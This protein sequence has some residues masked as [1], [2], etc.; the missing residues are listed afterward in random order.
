MRVTYSNQQSATVDRSNTVIFLPRDLTV[1][2]PRASCRAVSPFRALPTNESSYLFVQQS[3]QQSAARALVTTPSLIRP[4]V[5]TIGRTAA[6][7]RTRFLFPS[8]AR[9]FSTSLATMTKVAVCQILSTNDPAHNLAVSSKVI[10]DAVAAGAKVS[11][12]QW[13]SELTVGRLPS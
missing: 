7:Q 1:G 12:Y 13:C 9:P 3:M 6:A 11:F 4:R 10:R 8:R 5:Y 2:T